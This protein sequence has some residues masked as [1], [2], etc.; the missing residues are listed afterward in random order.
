MDPKE[1]RGGGFDLRYEE[2]VESLKG[3]ITGEDVGVMVVGERVKEI[4]RQ[5]RKER[6]DEA[7]RSLTRKL[8]RI[9]FGVDEGQSVDEIDY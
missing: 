2:T 8:F 9:A 7:R 1:R 3:M 4:M 6:G 5:W